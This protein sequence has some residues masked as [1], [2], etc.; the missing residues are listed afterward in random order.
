M[1]RPTSQRQMLINQQQMMN[2]KMRLQIMIQPINPKAQMNSRKQMMINSMMM[3]Q[4]TKE[5]NQK[6]RPN[7]RLN[8]NPKISKFQ[9]QSLN[10]KHEK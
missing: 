5:L 1:K 3:M 2:Q 4:Q 8:L 7:L 9:N 10:L 6:L